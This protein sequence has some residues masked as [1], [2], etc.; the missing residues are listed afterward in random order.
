M[1][2]NV[3][4]CRHGYALLGAL[5]WLSS[6][7]QSPPGPPA[8]TAAAVELPPLKTAVLEI[9][10]CRWPRM[11]RA[12]GSF[13]ADEVAVVGAKVPGRITAVRVDLGDTVAANTVLVE[14]DREDLKLQIAQV[15]A[16]LAQARA[17]VG[18]EPDGPV[19]S[20]NPQNSPPVREARAV[21]DEAQ[22]KRA[23]LE[24]LRSQN[25]LTETELQQVQ[26]AEKVA[27]AQF[28]SALNA[29]NEKIALIRVRAAELAVARQRFED[30]VTIAPFPGQVLE[31][32]VAPGTYVQMGAPLVT[33]VR[34]NPLR[35]QGT[36]PERFAW[37]LALGQEVRLHIERTT[38][39]CVARITRIS[40]ALNQS[41]RALL[42]EASVDNAGGRLRAGL[43]AEADVVLDPQQTAIVVPAA[44][45]TEFAGTEKVW[46]VVDGKS[47]EQ[48][49]QTGERRGNLVAITSGLL[50]GDVILAEG[51]SGRVGRVE[52]TA[53]NRV[54][55]PDAALELADH[56]L[57]PA[58]DKEAGGSHSTCDV[59][60]ND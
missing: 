44:A 11:A 49:V 57:E 15:E 43:F 12:Q 19:E 35:Y 1:R 48:L 2:L 38:E 10:A 25:A 5:L 51:R 33:L 41:S 18:L 27:D 29:V 16:Q 53:R 24:R 21:L 4:Q 55:T 17:A 40:P 6:C 8:N 58:G 23:R 60:D 3:R 28:S 32:H 20:L 46:K 45:I 13:V 39:P 7:R 52:V 30:A 56:P 26:A 47:I 37:Q 42:F 50:E 31:R 59:P 14:L 54:Q 22:T 34:T 9:T 36:L